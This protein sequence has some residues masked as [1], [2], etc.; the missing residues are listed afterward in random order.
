[1]IFP[2]GL[3]VTMVNRPVLGEGHRAFA[4]AGQHAECRKGPAVSVAVLR[5]CDQKR[6]PA[7]AGVA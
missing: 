1:M 5:P 6:F 2:P 7:W 3:M 4:A